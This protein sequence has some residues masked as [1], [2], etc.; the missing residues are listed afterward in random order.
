VKFL[1]LLAIPLMIPAAALIV[2]CSAEGPVCAD[3]EVWVQNPPIYVKSGNTMMPISTG[4][5]CV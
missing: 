2:A 5:R 1:G 3:G 4:G